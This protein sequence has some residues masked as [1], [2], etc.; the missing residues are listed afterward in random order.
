MMFLTEGLKAKGFYSYDYTINDNKVYQQTY[1]V[2]LANVNTTVTPNTVTYVPSQA[3]FPAYVNR[4]YNKG[5]NTLLQ[6]S[7]DYSHTFAKNHNVQA[8]ALY[9]ETG[10]NSDN[11][12]AQR[13][14]TLPVDQLG[15]GTALNQVAGQNLNGI[16]GY[17]TRS[18][19]GKLHYDFQSKYLVD[20][21]ARDDGSSRFASN[22]RF[23][24]FP[25]VLA[26][27]RLSEEPF[28]KKI[29]GLSFIDNLKFRG[30]YGVT[31]TLP[32]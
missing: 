11:F 28:F 30:S 32:V 17:A 8:L 18:F 15:A 27:Y 14:V 1:N 29:S 21:S 16:Q 22:K 5:V 9:E 2:Y 24:L 3:Q 23:G 4:S 12:S 25:A 26:A 10:I 6:F 13:N 19:V 31:G 20:F 7:L